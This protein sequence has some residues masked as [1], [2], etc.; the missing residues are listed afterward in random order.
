MH[1]G[2]EDKM[3]IEKNGK[4]YEAYYGIIIREIKF[5]GV[6]GISET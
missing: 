4:C 1:Y 3:Y 5:K 6:C 2:G